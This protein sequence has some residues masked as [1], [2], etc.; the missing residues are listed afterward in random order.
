MI[1]GDLKSIYKL[2]NPVLSDKAIVD[3]A[4]Y[5]TQQAIEK[6]LKYILSNVYGESEE[7]KDFKIHSITKLI[8]KI[9]VYDNNFK[10]NNKDL[11]INAIKLT[12]W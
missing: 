6:S 5:L 8:K 3:V 2:I 1:R 12:S 11:V 9:S 7:S 10:K 4:A